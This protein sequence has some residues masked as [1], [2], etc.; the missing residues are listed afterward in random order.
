M[1]PSDRFHIETLAVHAGRRPDPTTG[2]VM[3]PIHLSTTFERN[4]DG[5]YTDGYVYT[6][7]ENPNRR[8]LEECLAVLEGG[9][10]A[11]AFS[12]GMAASTSVFQAL[13][14]GSHILF[15][16]DVYFGTSRML[17]E[18]LA[19]WGLTYSVVDMTDPN[20]VKAALQPTT[21]LVWVETPSNPLLKITDIA[22]VAEIA[23]EANARCVVDNTWP[24]PIGQ[25]P[26]D[27]GADMV[28][29]A[30]TKYLGGHSDLL[31][32]A[33]IARENDEAFE[34]IRLIQTIG[35]AVPAPFDCWLLMRSIRT[36]PYRMRAH[37]ENAVRVAAFLQ[38][39]PAVRRGPLSRARRA[40]GSRRCG[41]PDAIVW[42]Y[43]V[44]SGEGRRRSGDG[45]GRPC[46]SIHARDQPGR[47]RKPDR[48]P[49]LGRRY[50]LSDAP[51]SVAAVDRAG[52]SRRLD[53]R[54]GSGAG[55]LK[56]SA[57]PYWQQ[58]AYSTC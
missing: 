28:M 52:A 4:A 56:I 10:V 40:S 53:R 15:P 42:R 48:T 20:A 32:G 47:Y 8:S 29:H 58:V 37:T 31:G 17:R 27:L 38:D 46:A 3:P 9:A 33:V 11:A 18:I 39:H 44:G 22:A 5:S 51:R 36:L 50:R 19:P 26:L 49:G 16:D 2:A 14:P 23:H 57:G 7:S 54:S 21:R 6:R 1:H 12:S 45:C 34:R 13:A 43:A 25:R 55:A 35:G 30:T 24:S 41:P